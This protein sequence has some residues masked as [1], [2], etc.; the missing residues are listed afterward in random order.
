M[1]FAALKGGASREG[2]SFDIVPL[3]PALKGGA[4]GALAGLPD[5]RK[6]GIIRLSWRVMLHL[7]TWPSAVYC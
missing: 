1:K 2:V 5:E 3:D 6:S 7:D 4:Y